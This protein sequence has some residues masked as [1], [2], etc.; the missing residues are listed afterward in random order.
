LRPPFRGTVG[1]GPGSAL[2]R[3]DLRLQDDRP[4][5]SSVESLR[6][7]V[8]SLRSRPSGA[9]QAPWVRGERGRQ[10]RARGEGG[11][12]HGQE[13]H[14]ASAISPGVASVRR[15]DARAD[16]SRRILR[17]RAA[18]TLRKAQARFLPIA[19]SAGH[20]SLQPDRTADPRAKVAS[21]HGGRGGAVPGLDRAARRMLD[22]TG[23]EFHAQATVSEIQSTLGT[24][25]FMR[26]GLS[27]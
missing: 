25:F 20:R 6:H 9:A 10:R 3:E 2:S 12:E 8:R 7:E 17:G 13:G 24:T 11:E 26:S 1:L 15:A 14:A 23:D 22:T 19:R 21:R 27:R 18:G 5:K 4:L 16:W